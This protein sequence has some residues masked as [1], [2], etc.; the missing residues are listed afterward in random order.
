MRLTALAGCFLL[1]AGCSKKEAE[2]AADTTAMAP[3]PA[4]AP[5][6]P[7]SLASVAGMWNVNVKPEGRDSVATT[8]VLNATDSTAWT[9]AFPKGKPIAMRVTGVRGD[10]IITETDWFDSSVR[11]GLKARSSSTAWLQNGKLV[12][13]TVVHYQT[14]GA[15]TVRTFDTEGTK[16]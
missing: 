4:A 1:F 16:K 13:K 3:A 9:F 15:D 2:P 14:T 5:A 8:Y 11:P 12:G 6:A 10:T 7:V